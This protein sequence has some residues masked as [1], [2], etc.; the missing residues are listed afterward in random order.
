MKCFYHPDRDAVAQCSRCS[1]ACCRDCIEDVGGAMLCKSCMALEQQ[2][3]LE[4]EAQE[5]A[6]RESER[7]MARKRI[8]RSKVIAVAFAVFGAV[9]ALVMSTEAN[10]PK[11][12]L[13]LFI[14]GLA[15]G[16]AY[17]GWAFYWGF[18]PIWR[19]WR[20]LL[21]KTGCFIVANPVFI[22]LF[23]VW[24]PIVVAGYYAPFGGGIAQYRKCRRVADGG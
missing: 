12:P 16:E 15:A 21:S 24:V 9:M 6:E 19:W 14:L 4:S 1:K 3:L 2:A 11:I 23:L 5:V 22:I 8:R 13:P 20:G 10:P 17:I 7:E 18:P